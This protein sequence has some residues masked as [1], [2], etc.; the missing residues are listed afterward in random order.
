MKKIF[1]TVVCFF[2]MIICSSFVVSNA[3]NDNLQVIPG[4]ES[5]G[6]RVY[7]GVEVVGKYAVETPNGKSMPWKN[8]NILKNDIIVS[9]DGYKIATNDDL[10]NA[11][12]RASNSVNLVIKR[13][14]KLINTVSKVVITK[15]NE[16]SLGLYLKD[17]IMGVGTISFYDDN[18]KIYSALGH[19]IYDDD[20]LVSVTSGRLMLSTV[21]G[22]KKATNKHYGEKR[23]II[24]SNVIGQIS[25][26]KNTG[27][28]GKIASTYI[29]KKQKVKVASPS[30]VKCKQASVYTVLEGNKVEK[31]NVEI[32][33]TYA[34]ATI[35]TKGLKIRV[36]D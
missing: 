12:E 35:D 4:G 29:P 3:K 20:Q 25:S 30:E 24:Q 26:V 27:V 11:L 2:V 31:F 18:Q 32:I 34:Q 5:I 16:K 21:S 10:M 15:N 13:D 14:N 1:I 36:T 6:V 19:G 22:I 8:C 7:T 23:A 33:D 17:Q 28:Y 9:I